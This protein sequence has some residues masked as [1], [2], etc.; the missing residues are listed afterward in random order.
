[1]IKPITQSD[2]LLF[3]YN[4]AD[5]VTASV[6]RENLSDN[7]EWQS[8]LLELEAFKSETRSFNLSP[9]STTLA[10][11]LEESRSQLEHTL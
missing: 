3:F 8:Y 1:M 7:Q 2:L 6:I 10:I 5:E 4:E 9:N 11:I